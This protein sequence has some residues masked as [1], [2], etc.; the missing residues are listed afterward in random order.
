MFLGEFEGMQ[1]KKG[2][3]DKSVFLGFLQNYFRAEATKRKE[4][5]NALIIVIV[6]DRGSAQRDHVLRAGVSSVCVLSADAADAAGAVAADLPGC[7]QAVGLQGVGRGVSRGMAE[8]AGGGCAEGGDEE[9]MEAS[10]IPDNAAA[11]GAGRAEAREER[12]AKGHLFLDED[13]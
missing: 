2:E 8:T 5:M 1:S 11:G 4:S 13:R 12:G 3:A 9:R 7:V 10:S 6:I